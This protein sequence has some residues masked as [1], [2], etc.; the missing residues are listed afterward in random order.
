MRPNTFD[1]LGFALAFLIVIIAACNNGEET[2]PPPRD[3]AAQRAA[4]RTIGASR[5]PGAQGVQGA[6]KAADS[7][8]ARQRQLDSIAKAP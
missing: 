5:L 2:P 3:A 7:A 6:L 1:L 4:D 8:A